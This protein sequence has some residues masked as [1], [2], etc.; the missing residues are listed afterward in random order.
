MKF[1]VIWRGSINF[2]TVLLYCVNSPECPSDSFQNMR[3]VEIE[4]IL[5][6]L[7]ANLKS[8]YARAT[9]GPTGMNALGI[10]GTEGSVPHD[11]PLYNQYNRYKKGLQRQGIKA[12]ANYETWYKANY[13]KG[14]TKY[15]SSKSKAPYRIPYSKIRV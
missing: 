2:S 15:L 4:K 8:E 3:N 11:A 7:L 13:G 5:F 9:K 6:K 10:S 14:A 12:I 1:I